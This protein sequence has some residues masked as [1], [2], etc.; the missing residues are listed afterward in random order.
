MST[1]P[2]KCSKWDGLFE[3]DSIYFVMFIKNPTTNLAIEKSSLYPKKSFKSTRPKKYSKWDGLF[4]IDFILFCS[5]YKEHN[6]SFSY[7]EKL[8]VT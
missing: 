1:R 5:V 8:I 4:E 3:I 2:K 6:N 7:R